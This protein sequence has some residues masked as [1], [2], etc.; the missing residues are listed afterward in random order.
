ME[1][2]CSLPEA[3]LWV[4]GSDRR[5]DYNSR[6]WHAYKLDPFGSKM[7]LKDFKEGNNIIG[8]LFQNN[9]LKNSVKVNCSGDGS[10]Q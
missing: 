1:E 8:V 7:P 4:C 5:W 3:Q 2:Q 10:Q 6:M 9:P